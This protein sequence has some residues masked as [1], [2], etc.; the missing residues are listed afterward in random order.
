MNP[1]LL[2]IVCLIYSIVTVNSLREREFAMSLVYFSYALS[3]VGFI[4]HEYY[5][6]SGR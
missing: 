6:S 5:K 2:G 3:L 4:V 1:L